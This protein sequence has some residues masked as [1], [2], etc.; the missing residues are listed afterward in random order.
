MAQSGICAVA[1]PGDVAVGSDQHGSGRCYLAQDRKLPISDV[2]GVDQPTPDRA[3]GVMSKPP[4]SPRLRSTAL[5]IVQQG[6]YPQRAVA[7]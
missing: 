1:D 7:R 5:G 6:E 2:F 3:H 4:G